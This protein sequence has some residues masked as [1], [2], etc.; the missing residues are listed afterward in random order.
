MHN[1]S[2]HTQIK[3]LKNDKKSLQ[4]KLEKLINKELGINKETMIDLVEIK[5]SSKVKIKT[6]EKG[7]KSVTS[8][9]LL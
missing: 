3:K 8:P 9:M 4:G 2:L 1:Q 6:L 7:T 5:K